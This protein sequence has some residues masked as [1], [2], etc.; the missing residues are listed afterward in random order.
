M[1]IVS[2]WFI[3]PPLGAGS[4][5]EGPCPGGKADVTLS[6]SLADMQQMFTGNLKPLSAYMSGRLKVPNGTDSVQYPTFMH[7]LF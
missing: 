2:T 7:L 6:L 3:C 4:V 1:T 5:G